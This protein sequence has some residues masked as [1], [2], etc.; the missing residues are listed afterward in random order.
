MNESRLP[1]DINVDVKSTVG[2]LHVEARSRVVLAEVDAS[3]V[4]LKD[5][6]DDFGDGTDLGV[7][8]RVV[9]SDPFVGEGEAALDGVAE[10]VDAV[11][12]HA[13]KVLEVLEH[14]PGTVSRVVPIDE[15]STVTNHAESCLIHT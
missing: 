1:I 3:G 7:G 14:E 5:L 10:D 12:R 2:H 8:P 4:A 11:G 13:N 6:L 9:V 15:P